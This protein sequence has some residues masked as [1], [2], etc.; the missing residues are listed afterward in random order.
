M[1]RVTLAVQGKLG[2]MSL[3]SF[4]RVL[5]ESHAILAELDRAV[6]QQRNGTLRW[7][8]SGLS[9]GSVVVEAESRVIR[10]ETD[11]GPQVT[12]R[13]VDGIHTIQTEAITPALFSLDSLTAMRRIVRILGTDGVSG[14][15][16]DAPES[17][18]SVELSATAN[19]N[20]QA[21]VGVHHK[22]L[23]S[24]EGRLELISIH[25]KER[26]FNVYHA[27]TQKA[28]R[29]NL[30]KGMEEE[31]VRSLGRRVVVSGEVSYNVRR[32][33]VRV[34][35]DHM[36]MLKAENDLPSIQNMLGLASDI[37]GELT[38]EEYIRELRDG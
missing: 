20:I 11:F 29:C 16:V 19:E 13:F 32:E 26:R 28:V 9:T 22:S 15:A 4:L 14:L 10:G 33:P 25:A 7:V 1:A 17:D 8:V 12:E 37:T 38:T 18:K 27:I 30:S 34:A 35:V 36:R 2:D 23:G 3:D 21:L 24:V 5:K 31:V 6:S